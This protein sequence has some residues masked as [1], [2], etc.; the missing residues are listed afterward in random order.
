[1]WHIVCVTVQLYV[2]E[3]KVEIVEAD[4]R[5]QYIEIFIQEEVSGIDMLNRHH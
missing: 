4:G 5:Y 1:M 2:S 3:G